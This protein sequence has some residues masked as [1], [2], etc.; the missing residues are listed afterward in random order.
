[1]NQVQYDYVPDE[2]QDEQPQD[3]TKAAPQAD[4]E[5]S[6][7]VVFEKINAVQIF[8]DGGADKVI[9]DIRR[10]VE[11]VV[12]DVTT[13]NGRKEI[14]SLAYKVACTKT[15]L[16]DAGKKIKDEAQRTV[17]TVDAERKK[18]RD[19]LDALKERVRKPLT[20]Y[21]Q[22]EK[23]RVDTHRRILDNI[24]NGAIFDHVDPEADA[25][26]V[27]IADLAKAYDRCWQEFSDQAKNAYERSRQTLEQM[28]GDRKKR[29]AE[30]AELERLRKEKEE[31]ERKDREDAIREEERERARKALDQE[32]T[33]ALAR[34]EGAIFIPD[35]AHSTAIEVIKTKIEAL[36]DRDWGGYQDQ[37]K[38]MYES[39]I[40][41]AD[42][43]LKEAI[44]REEKQAKEAAEQQ[45]QQAIEAERKCQAEKEAAEK[46]EQEKREADKQ[47]RLKVN[48]AVTDA[49]IAIVGRD[50]A[51][52]VTLAIA[53]GKIPHVKIEY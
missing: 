18:I 20:D 45:K 12:T 32:R 22:R 10:Q 48:G 50:K 7:L 3:E 15:A 37:A 2:N 41:N 17:N 34:L 31:R 24:T 9:E 53:E 39:G 19:E 23:N 40:K 26:Q 6:E 35:D 11:S 33:D 8:S 27:R 5:S 21:E 29:D 38:S 28:L 42:V 25:I 44:E 14:A 30:R 16:D 13:K 51:P 47:H 1:M 49:L 46:A 4:S 52:S 36:Y 43:M